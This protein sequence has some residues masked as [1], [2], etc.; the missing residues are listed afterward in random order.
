VFKPAHGLMRDRIQEAPLRAGLNG[1]RSEMGLQEKIAGNDDMLRWTPLGKELKIDLM[2]VFMGLWHECE[3]PMILE[4]HGLIS[5]H[6]AAKIYRR[7][8]RGEDPEAVLTPYVQRAFLAHFK[9]K[10]L[11]RRILQ[12]S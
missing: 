2:L 9:K 10:P 5:K 1:A 3:V 7:C 12:I 4:D 6:Q 11:V 8:G